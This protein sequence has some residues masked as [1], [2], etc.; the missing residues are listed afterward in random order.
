MQES[1]K[2]LCFR[3]ILCEEFKLRSEKNPAYSS[4]AFA[5]D[6]NLSPAF[7]S[8]VLSGKRNLSEEKAVAIAE[9]LK[10]NGQKT[11]EFIASIRF[12]LSSD[13]AYRKKVLDEFFN[14]YPDFKDYFDTTLANFH[15]ISDWYYFAVVELSK[16]KSIKLSPKS[17]H[18][19]LGLSLEQAH[20]A[21]ETLE[22]VGLLVKEDGR[23]R[24]GKNAYLAEVINSEDIRKFHKQHLRLAK[25]A[26]DYQKVSE[27]SL[28]GTTMA[29]SKDK[30]S[31]A[32]ELINKLHL[33]LMKL[34]DGDDVDSVYHLGVQF[35][36]LD[37][38]V[39][40]PQVDRKTS[41]GRPQ[42]DRQTSEGRP[43][44]GR[45]TTDRPQQEKSR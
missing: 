19:R 23:Y 45:Q 14:R 22:D 28:S 30:L 33:D 16:N 25:V 7:L 40:R 36:Q 21:L 13:E 37:R 8:Q 26:A 15:P 11:D 39:G 29:F 38:P 43:H 31:E 10:F 44:G 5:R 42:V 9:C 24:A 2:S 27:R 18:Q 4:R 41:K 12:E 17:L 6:L 34:S 1:P 32:Q 3:S 35:Y 20:E